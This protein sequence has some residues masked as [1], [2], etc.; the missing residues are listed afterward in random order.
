MAYTIRLTP[1]GGNC[2]VMD[3]KLQR[4]HSVALHDDICNLINRPENR[5]AIKRC[6]GLQPLDAYVKLKDNKGWQ[7]ICDLK[8][9]Y[10]HTNARP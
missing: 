9:S 2:P 8:L 3:L 4:D 10:S 7:L 6:F 1:D 5:K